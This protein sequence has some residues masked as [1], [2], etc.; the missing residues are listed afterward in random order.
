VGGGKLGGRGREWRMSIIV[1]GGRRGVRT[2]RWFWF[3]RFWRR[4]IEFRGGACAAGMIGGRK[5]FG[6]GG[7]GWGVWGWVGFGPF[8]RV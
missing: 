1:G 5:R 6:W 4:R 3:L 8:L 7:W 2:S